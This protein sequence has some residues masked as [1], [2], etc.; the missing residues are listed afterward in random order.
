[1]VRAIWNDTVLAASEIA[2][3]VAFWRGVR[4]ETDAEGEA[5]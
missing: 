4:V 2:D 3:R 5:S 1:M